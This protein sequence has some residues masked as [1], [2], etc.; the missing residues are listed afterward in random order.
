M[1]AICWRDWEQN[2][3]LL[4]CSSVILLR[5]QIAKI[6]IAMYSTDYVVNS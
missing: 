3:V 2:H 1:D 6:K 4:Y 5:E